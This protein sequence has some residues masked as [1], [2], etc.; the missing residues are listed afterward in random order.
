[1][2]EHILSDKLF[3]FVK[4]VFNNT[5]EGFDDYYKL[6]PDDVGIIRKIKDEVE[7]VFNNLYNNNKTSLA[8]VRNILEIILNNVYKTILNKKTPDKIQYML[9]DKDFF[10]NFSYLYRLEL[11]FLRVIGNK[12]HHEDNEDNSPIDDIMAI[13]GLWKICEVIDWYFSKCYLKGGIKDKLNINYHNDKLLKIYRCFNIDGSYKFSST[14]E[15]N[16]IKNDNDQINVFIDK[17]IAIFNQKHFSIPTGHSNKNIVEIIDSKLDLDDACFIESLVQ[18]FDITLILE[19]LNEIN[20]KCKNNFSA[21]KIIVFGQSCD[22]NSKFF[23]ILNVIFKSQI[24]AGQLIIVACNQPYDE[25]LVQNLKD[26]DLFIFQFDD[27]QI[28][29]NTDIELLKK[30]ESLYNPNKKPD[31]RLYGNLIYSCSSY[32]RNFDDFNEFREHIS[33]E[34]SRYFYL[35]NGVSVYADLNEI[36]NI[37][38]LNENI[39]KPIISGLIKSHI[40][41]F[42]NEKLLVN[43]IKD[44][45]QIKR[46]IYSDFLIKH[47]KK[48]DDLKH[49]LFDFFRE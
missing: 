10:K 3:E 18:N 46:E 22:L 34:H 7:N 38:I 2:K 12:G 16:I 20:H 5:I 33:K 4:I 25:S 28:F 6:Y 9:Q 26:A 36:N 23:D 47:N 27:I 31:G 1:M 15:F 40:K 49:K 41:D 35:D 45:I 8:S 17:I 32:Y 19:I 39:R 21:N 43:Y 42:S 24:S 37:E 44:K 14:D 13:S 11:D 30:F 29:S 48:I